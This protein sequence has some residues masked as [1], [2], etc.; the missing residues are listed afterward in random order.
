MN[1]LETLNRTLFLM[2]NATA[3]TPEWQI[4]VARLTADYVIYLVPLTLAALWLSGDERRRDAAVRACCVAV[5]ALGLN[6][7][8]GSV[9][10]HP[11]PFVIGIGHTFLEHAPDSSFPS[12]HATVL[13]SVALTFLYCNMRRYG[14]LML[15][16]GLAVAWARL[17]VGVHFPLD[18]AGAVA[19]ACAAFLLVMP[20]WALG[21][22]A[23]TRALIML[24]RKL[25]AVP[26]DHGWLSR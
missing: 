23:T 5:L 6:Q 2:I 9:W 1:T 24:Y 22:P 20:L 8:I 12:D 10:Q 7:L 18:M 16:S 13:A 15:L 3:S 4:M 21:G 26:I 25:L 17:F 14:V 19:V 11:R